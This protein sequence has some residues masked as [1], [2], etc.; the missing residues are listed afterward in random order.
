MK[1]D[2]TT[3]YYTW[4]LCHV[5]HHF[6]P[7][8]RIHSLALHLQNRAN[9][10]KWLMSAA[11]YVYQA[12]K[13]QPVISKEV[14][15]LGRKLGRH[16]EQI[17][18]KLLEEKGWTITNFTSQELYPKFGISPTNFDIKARWGD[19]SERLIE[20][21]TFSE[22][23]PFTYIYYK[24][25]IKIDQCLNK[26]K[27]HFHVFVRGNDVFYVRTSE[28]KYSGFVRNMNNENQNLKCYWVI[29]PQCLRV[30]K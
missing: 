9:D 19:S 7:A 12:R 23:T 15:L 6:F 5:A 1:V 29:D 17:V 28:I 21:K 10:Q 8:E 24:Q 11:R 20:I 25:K 13:S 22:D 4:W 2:Y 18:H 3:Q 26:Q 16:G 30:L 14:N 27:N